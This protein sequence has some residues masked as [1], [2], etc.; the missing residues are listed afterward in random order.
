[1][2]RPVHF[3]ISADDPARAAAFY[4]DV[5]GWKVDRW[6]EQEYWLLTTG[7]KSVPGIDGAVMPRQEPGAG[8]INTVDVADLEAA[9][10][11]VTAHGGKV[12]FEPRDIPGVGRFVYAVDTEGNT[13]GL[14]Q[15]FPNAAM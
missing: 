5:F 2:G 14:M 7:E 3:E 9:I 6:G 1:M 11:A 15:A 12:L 10:T 8:T 4:Q 13:F